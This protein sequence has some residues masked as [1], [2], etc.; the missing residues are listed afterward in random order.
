MPLTV[1]DPWSNPVLGSALRRFSNRSFFESFYRQIAGGDF[2]VLSKIN[3]GVAVAN[4]DDFSDVSF[5]NPSNDVPG[6]E[7]RVLHLQGG[8]IVLLAAVSIG[9]RLTL[10]KKW[11]GRR[12][13]PDVDGSPLA[14]DSR[15]ESENS[16]ENLTKKI[17]T[18]DTCNLV[19]LLTRSAGSV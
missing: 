16:R 19:Q 7:G 13:G 10:I 4:V 9:N 12:G 15:I 14:G 11:L 5:A 1:A 17:L 8:R 18:Y 3:G 6:V 2:P